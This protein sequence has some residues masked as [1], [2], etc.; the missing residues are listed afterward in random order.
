MWKYFGLTLCLIGMTSCLLA[1]GYAIYLTEP[2]S[3]LIFGAGTIAFLLSYLIIKNEDGQ[4]N[5]F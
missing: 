4:S 1:T 5:N 2:L 3:I